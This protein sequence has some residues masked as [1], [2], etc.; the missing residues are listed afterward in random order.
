[1]FAPGVIAQEGVYRYLGADGRTVI[2]ELVTRDSLESMGRLLARRPL[3]LHHPKSWVTPG[4]I[5]ALQV[6]DSGDEVVGEEVVEET[7]GGYGRFRLRVPLAVRRQ[8]ALDSYA[9]GATTQLSPGFDR[10][11]IFEPGVHDIFGAYDRI[12]GEVYEV[13][14]IALVDTARGGDACRVMDGADAHDGVD[15]VIEI[16]VEEPEEEDIEDEP[17]EA[18][19]T[20]AGQTQVASAQATP[21]QDAAPPTALPPANPGQP[22]PSTASDAPAASA[23]SASTDA[24][25]STTPQ[26]ASIMDPVAL[27]N[28]FNAALSAAISDPSGQMMIDLVRTMSYMDAFK[29][30][31]VQSVGRAMGAPPAMTGDAEGEVPPEMDPGVKAALDGYMAGALKPVMDRLDAIEAKINGM[32][33]MAADSAIRAEVT[34]LKG[35]VSTLSGKVGTLTKAQDAAD[36]SLRAQREAAQ[37]SEDRALASKFGLGRAAD[38]LDGPAC[39][40]HVKGKLIAARAIGQD[41]DDVAVRIAA[42]A[43]L[44]VAPAPAIHAQGQDAGIGSDLPRLPAMKPRVGAAN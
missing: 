18:T 16:E 28:A 30:A 2:R 5:G 36:A 1:L 24:P 27:Q 39:L 43:T 37:L 22:V 25:P 3:T 7:L 10:E 15:L 23:A 14:H 32:G 12:R 38:S 9:S 33:T 31:Q 11:L 44:A 34:A 13:N 19:P 17:S 29:I 20:Q 21:A 40:A 42:K 8:D 4:N 35:T 6:G 26:E 41:A